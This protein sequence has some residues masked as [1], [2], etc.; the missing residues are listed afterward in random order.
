MKTHII[1]LTLCASLFALCGSASAEP[2]QLTRNQASELFVALAKLEPGLNAANAITAADNLTELRPVIEAFDKGKLAAQRQ[3]RALPKTEDLEAKAQAIID[4][5]DAKGA[6]SV[7]LDLA[8]LDLTPDE[9]T[10]AKIPPAQLAIIR[11]HLKPKK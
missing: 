8:R 1:I 11:Q 9:I 2:M 5:L 7:K 3:I 6:E 10:A 4:A